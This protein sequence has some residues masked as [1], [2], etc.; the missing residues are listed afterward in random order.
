MSQAQ[1]DTLASLFDTA[2]QVLKDKGELPADW[3]NS[4]QITRTKDV[5]H[6]DFAS[7]IALSAAKA[8]KSNPRALA[9]SIVDA[10]SLIHI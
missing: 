8:A 3:Q 4:S 6:G 7:N 10:L 1:I 5:S 2:V 9:Q